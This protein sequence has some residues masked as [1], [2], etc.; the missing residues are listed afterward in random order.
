MLTRRTRQFTEN[1]KLS[2]LLANIHNTKLLLIK[3]YWR[4]T[5]TDN[6]RKIKAVVHFDI[7]F[8]ISILRSLGT[9]TARERSSVILNV[10][11]SR[12][13][14]CSHYRKL[15]LQPVI[16][17]LVCACILS[18]I[19]LRSGGISMNNLCSQLSTLIAWA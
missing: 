17:D 12:V 11:T 8:L 15:S 5:K 19:I 3:Y 13:F 6:I 10:S 9:V 18:P 16:Q 2:Q 1:D 7:R 14:L 4:N